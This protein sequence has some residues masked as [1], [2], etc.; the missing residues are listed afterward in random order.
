ML[1]APNAGLS[2]ILHE[3]L[4]IQFQVWKKNFEKDLRCLLIL[5]GSQISKTGLVGVNWATGSALR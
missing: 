1:L 3:Y 2:G 4:L 5:T